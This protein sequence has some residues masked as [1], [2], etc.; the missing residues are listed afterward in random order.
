M[1]SF[2]VANLA[3]GHAW[4]QKD[5]DKSNDD[6]QDKKEKGGGR[7]D[8]EKDDDEK[9]DDE[10]DDDE[11]DDDEKDDDEK[12][13]DNKSRENRGRDQDEENDE[14]ED[15]SPPPAPSIG[16][17]QSGASPQQQPQSPPAAPPAE[18]EREL[19]DSLAATDGFDTLTDSGRA[20]SDSV[21][22]SEAGQPELKAPA[23]VSLQSAIQ[24]GDRP[25]IFGV[26]GIPETPVITV[27]SAQ[28]LYVADGQS[29]EITFDS[30][31]DGR[32]SVEIRS[33]DGSATSQTLAGRLVAG[34]NSVLWEGK[35]AS[36]ALLPEG[37]YTYYISAESTEGTREP[38]AGGDG[39]IL[40]TASLPPPAF[41][42]TLLLPFIAAAGAAGAAALFVERRRRAVTIFVPVKAADIV[43]DIKERYPDAAVADYIEPTAGGTAKYIGVTIQHGADKEWL[44]EIVAKAKEMANVDSVRLSHRGKMQA[45]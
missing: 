42:A 26:V 6:K 28:V 5:D 39:T 29:A 14:S 21:R 37:Q 43:D 23:E 8:D 17:G 45:L 12:D 16:S 31:A 44:A 25:A 13:D 11:K 2:L 24:L 34:E 27:T 22:L 9:D 4:A 41:D 7:D 30:T 1:A 3:T 19:G 35:S 20:V 40:V 18:L 38:P 36:G 10:K 32:Y 33:D 15:D